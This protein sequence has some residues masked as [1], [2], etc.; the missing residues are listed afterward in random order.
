MG[1]TSILKNHPDVRMA[2]DDN[3][4]SVVLP[5]IINMSTYQLNK[6]EIKVMSKG[7]K[8]C[9]TP[10]TPDIF[11]LKIAVKEL[12][13]KLELQKY[14]G[15]FSTSTNDDP[16]K[17]KSNYIPPQ[18]TDMVF[19][20][21]I[22]EIK[23]TAENIQPVLPTY[24]N[25]TEAERRA[26]TTLQNNKEIIIKT[27][28]KGSAF[29]IMNTSYYKTKVEERLNK[30]D[31]YKTHEKNPDNIV[32]NRLN[33]FLDKHKSI[34]T[35]KEK[36][37]LKNP[38]FKTSNFVAYPKIHKS[39]FISKQVQNS[40]SSYIEMPI[41][42]DLKFRFIHA[43]P[44]SPT[45][46]LSELL[47]SLLK[48]YLQKIP[49][50]I[51][52][53]NDFLTK[54]P[55]FEK[56]EIS[57]I[58]FA[59]CDIVDMYSNIEV[60]LVIKSVTYWVSKF[61]TLL[62]S[63]FN[64]DFIIEGLEIV[65][66]NATFQFNN[67][68][69]SLQCGT[70]T[71]TQVAPTIANLVMGYLE[72]TLYQKVKNTFDENVQKYVIQNWKRFIDDGQI[73]WKK[74]FGD[75]NKFLAI[76]NDLHPKIKFT[77]DS[78]EKEISYLNILLYKSENKIET[79]IFYKETDTHDY[80]PYSSSHPRHTKNN[81]PNTL[82]RMICQIVSDLSVREKRLHEL[83]NWLLKSGYKS[84]VILNCFKKFD[85]V[86]CK[87]LRNKVNSGNDEDKIVFVQ[88]HN[89]NNPQIFGKI[90]NIFNSLKD[91]EGVEGTFNNTSLIKAEKQPLNLGRLLQ[92]S[93]FSTE[94]RPAQGVKK[95]KYAKCDPC[96]YIPE[97]TAVYF[98][99]HNK[100][101]IIKHNF[102][103]NAKNVI[104]KISCM[105]CNEFYIG[106]TVNLKQRIYG[107]KHKLFSDDDDLQK[108]YD[109]ISF[110]AKERSIPFTIVPFYQVK[111]ESLTARLTIEE[112]FIKKY[113]PKLNTY[114]HEKPHLNNKKR[115][116]NE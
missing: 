6:D 64:L 116:L 1:S 57:D 16:L 60:D 86:T 14:F 73:C 13:R 29:I 41:P 20:T 80:L 46:K 104:Y 12:T 35:K 84:E 42:P 81:V 98:N 79:D 49:S 76:L 114:F 95:C 101:F 8:F 43:G 61:P 113:N 58:L 70:G 44:C 55:D 82:A 105:G 109:H 65:L 63:R 92:K 30:E 75:F 5:K 59:T 111:Q 56:N 23:K 25:I 71:G 62:H 34:L 90:K 38:N 48:Q 99:G 31:L 4:L 115:K 78:S 100:P 51:K 74:S 83:K 103:C 33:T 52:D 67:R 40:N 18:S 10:N 39:T 21:K 96:K 15:N 28:D 32:M 112:Y 85:N 94:D 69:Y 27:A 68:F 7:P 88:L 87:D 50:Y 107:H 9:P 108:I 22:K 2:H 93:F 66:K 47:D 106:E 89:P 53:Y 72:I 37:Y 11:D 19:N 91:Y 36:L 102:D 54:L 17:I 97:T 77:S 24:Y 110:C 26:I 3:N 45:N